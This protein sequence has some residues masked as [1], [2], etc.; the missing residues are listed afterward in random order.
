MKICEGK[1]FCF[2]KPSVLSY[3]AV[4]GKAENEGPYGGEFDEVVQ[5]NKGGEDTWEQAESLFQTK[6]VGHVLRKAAL[7]PDKIDLMIAGDLLNQC[8]GSTY[9][10]KEYFIPYIGIFGACST[11]AEGLLLSAALVNAGYVDTAIAST[12]SHFSTA[13]R[14][15]RFPLNYGGVR[16]PTAQWTATAAGAALIGSSGKPPFIR[17]ATVGK[18]QDM[19]I[20]DMNNM[21][22]AMA[23]AAYDTLSRH[24]KHRASNPQDYDVIITG[25][26]GQVGSELLYDLFSRDGVDIKKYHKDCGLMIYDREK[27]DVHAGGSGCGCSASMM[28]GHFFKRVQSGELKRILY[29]A[30]GALMSPTV[31]QQGG[32]IPGIAHCVEITSV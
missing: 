1:T 4:V 8:V 14:Q 2:R 20:T 18:I 10:L 3:A 24:F 7:T 29:C 27:Q 19:G 11:F 17:A 30:T 25:D 21:G 22:A 32:S 16:T 23:G 9:G 28:C 31:V 12:S 26:L 5:D 15:F 6:A 13:E